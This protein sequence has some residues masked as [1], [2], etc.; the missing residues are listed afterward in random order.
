MR[1]D[2]DGRGSGPRPS[3]IVW[4]GHMAEKPSVWRES[5]KTIIRAKKPKLPRQESPR[6]EAQTHPAPGR[7]QPSRT[8]GYETV[9]TRPR[10]PIKSPHAWNS[11][12][13]TP[14]GPTPEPDPSRP[15]AWPPARAAM[16][17]PRLIAPWSPPAPARAR[18][19]SPYR[20]R[21]ARSIVARAS[22]RTPTG[23]DELLDQF[24][25]ADREEPSARACRAIVRQRG[26]GDHQ[27]Q[28]RREQ[29]DDRGSFHL[30]LLSVS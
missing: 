12:E 13:A 3:R 9:V 21:T 7:A 1:Q 25:P 16:R 19:T 10:R 28:E 6:E 23:S 20:R 8:Q 4:A 22:P 15:R 17:P 5:Q 2:S 11:R 26:R 29:H 18:E 24:R 30:L 27:Q 14:V